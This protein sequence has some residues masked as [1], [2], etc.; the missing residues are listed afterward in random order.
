MNIQVTHDGKTYNFENGA[1]VFIFDIGICHEMPDNQLISQHLRCW[2]EIQRSRKPLRASFQLLVLYS[3]VS[4][5]YECYLKDI[6]DTFTKF[7]LSFLRFTAL[8]KLQRKM[9]TLKNL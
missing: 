9:K 2:L 5:V 4:L 6:N 7:T 8:T 1:E 3:Y